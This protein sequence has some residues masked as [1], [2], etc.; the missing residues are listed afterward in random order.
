MRV[1]MYL[2]QLPQ[3]LLGMLLLLFLQGEK[4]HSL[5]GVTFYHA[6]CF[7]GG[8][9]LGDY[10]IISQLCE[11]SIRHEYGHS[12]QSR[13]LGWL[14]LPVVGIPSLLHAWLHDCEALGMT[15]YHYWTE[16][17]ADRLGKVERG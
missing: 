15:Y 8:I 5:S 9:S 14:Y 10:I 1:L 7:R 16:R 2:W 6:E 4:R 3:N 13:M 12:L 17:W 11:K